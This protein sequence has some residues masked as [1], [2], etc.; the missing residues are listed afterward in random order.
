MHADVRKQN[1]VKP[2]VCSQHARGRPKTKSR[3]SYVF[4]QRP[5]PA[6]AEGYMGDTFDPRTPAEC[7][8]DDRDPDNPVDVDDATWTELYGNMED[9]ES[10]MDHDPN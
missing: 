3:E 5:A 7:E 6:P 8:I 4:C 9:A 2:R 1:R 10:F